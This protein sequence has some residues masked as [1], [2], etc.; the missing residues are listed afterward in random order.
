MRQLSNQYSLKERSIRKDILQRLD[1]KSITC[2][3]EVFLNIHYLM[4]D[5]YRLPGWKVLLVYYES[6]Q[7][8]VVWFSVRDNEK[9]VHIVEDLKFLKNHMWYTDIISCTTDGSPS[10]GRAFYEVYP[11]S[12]HQRCLVHIQ[13]QVENYTTQKPKTRVWKALKSI[14]RY[15]TLSSPVLFSTVLRVFEILFLETINQTAPTEKWWWRY[16]YK[17]LRKGYMHIINALPYMYQFD[18]LKN[19][20]IPRSTNKLE[21]YFWVLTDECINEHRWL[22]KDRLLSLIILWMYHRNYK[23]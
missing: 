3:D 2:I 17:E 5:W 19:L 11:E 7:E 6:I 13:R 8:K 10:I 20:S 15:N 22:R 14:V 16:I 4:I 9:K 21:W 18:T 12:S 1:A 23:K